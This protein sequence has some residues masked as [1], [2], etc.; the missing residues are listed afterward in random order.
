MKTRY[1]MIVVA[2][3]SLMTLYVWIGR[4]SPSDEIVYQTVCVNRGTISRAVTATGVIRPVVGA[5]VNVGSRV[6]GTVEELPVKVGDIVKAGDLLGQLDPTELDAKVAQARA[7]LSLAR[8]QRALNQKTLV[9]Q[10][11]LAA[12]GFSSE[13]D[14]DVAARDLAVSEAQV[15]L[16]EARLRTAKINL[17][18]TRITAPIDGAIARVTTREG[19]TVAASFAA[20]NFVT[21]VDLE[22]LE[23]QAYV[24]ETD[25]GRVLVGQRATFTV[26][27]Y[28]EV[29]FSAVVTTIQPK[30]EI[31][32]SVVNYVVILN[33]DGVEGHCLRPEM[34]THLRIVLEDR[35]NVLT[36]PRAVLRHREGGQY[37]AVRRDSVWVEQVVRVGWRTELIAEVV[38]GLSEGDVVQANEK[39]TATNE[40]RIEWQ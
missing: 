4:A 18:F 1:W 20:P 9:R 37:V 6:S 22:R 14:V 29:D 5:E 39:T 7:E 8:A 36:I 34:T 21:I 35:A 13:E 12:A 28:P 25:I 10:R 19:E 24:D 23:I 27:T 31:Q 40:R 16:N 26:D 3:A 11:Q 17:G 30:A 33:F 38:T 15:E 2:L 32:N